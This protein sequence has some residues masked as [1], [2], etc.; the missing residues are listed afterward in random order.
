MSVLATRLRERIA[1]RSARTGVVGLGYVGLPLAVEL[2]RNGFHTTGIDLDARKVAAIN[3]GRVVHPR[4]ADRRRREQFRAAGRLDATTD[5]AIVAELDTINI[6]V[7]TPLRKTKDPDMSLHRVGGRERSRSTCTRACWSS[8]SRRPIP[9]TTEEVVQP[10]LEA[11]RPEGGRGLL[12]GLLARARRPG[13]PD[14]PDPQRAQGRRRHHARRAPRWPSA[15]YGAAIETIVP[16]SSTRVAEMVKLLENTFRAVN[17]GLVN[18]LALMCDRMGIDVWEVVDAAETKPF[19]FMPFYPGPGPRRPLHPDRSVLPVVE[20]EAER[21]R[22]ALHRAGRPDQRRD[23]A[24][25]RRQ[26]GR[27]AEHAAQGAQRLARC[28]SPASPTSATSTTCASRRRST[29]WGC[30]T[31]RG[32]QVVLHRPVRPDDRRARVGGRLRD[33]RR[34]GRHAA[35]FG[36]YD[37]VVIVTDHRAFDYQAMVEGGRPD[38]RHAQRDQGG[39]AERVPARRAAHPERQ[40]PRRRRCRLGGQPEEARHLA[41][42]RLQAGDQLMVVVEQVEL[43]VRRAPRP[44][45]RPCPGSTAVSRVPWKIWIGC[46]TCAS[47]AS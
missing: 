13:Q 1:S 21:L 36:Q 44:I 16:V 27:G 41:P 26:G 22:A 39:R 25:R 18:E 2:A 12:P 19:G 42:H 30:C 10:M 11:D 43:D 31:P 29:S 24:L 38:R 8:S 47:N 40:L 6:C 37:C 17:I 5:F 14:V 9:G 7:P 15:L 3:D 35:S 33:R 28:W 20:G 34:A 45:A 46:G 4:R 32:A 23:A